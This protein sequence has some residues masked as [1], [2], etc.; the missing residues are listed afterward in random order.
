[1]AIIENIG[2]T[3]TLVPLYFTLTNAADA[4]ATL[5]AIEATST[6]YTMPFGGS[7]IAIT[8]NGNATLATGSL[9]FSPSINGTTKTALVATASSAAAS[10][11]A[12]VGID[13]VNFAAGDLVG[14]KV[15][16]TATVS[17]TTI[18]FV[19]VVWV[20]LRGITY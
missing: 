1:M 18:D 4:D 9:A 12:T 2:V 19:V 20:L 5:V 3:D 14:A 8:F 6:A 17:A 10:G 15:V 7:I 13:T 16:H 11:R